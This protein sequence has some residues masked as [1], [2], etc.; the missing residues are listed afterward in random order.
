MLERLLAALTPIS[1]H[2]REDFVQLE[3]PTVDVVTKDGVLIDGHWV[4]K[5]QMRCGFD[6]QLYVAGW[7]YGKEWE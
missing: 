1:E 6:G 3:D 4:G 2:E 7:L 5:S